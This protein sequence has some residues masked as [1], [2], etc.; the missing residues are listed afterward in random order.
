[1]AIVARIPIVITGMGAADNIGRT[2]C[3]IWCPTVDDAIAIRWC[4]IFIGCPFKPITGLLRVTSL[5]YRDIEFIA[6][7]GCRGRWDGCWCRL[8]RWGRW[9]GGDV[10]N[11]LHAPC[12]GCRPQLAEDPPWLAFVVDLPPRAI[13]VLTGDGKFLNV[14]SHFNDRMSSAW[15]LTYIYILIDRQQR[16]SG[17][18][19]HNG[20]R[21][22]GWGFGGWRVWFWRRG[23]WRVWF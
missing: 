10:G 18:R 15:A 17:W 11:Y 12:I 20:Y 7:P 22:R 16:S 23:G 14:R 5:H 13:R 9:R 21:C 1:M 3:T 19:C 4:P 2:P 8:R 6:R